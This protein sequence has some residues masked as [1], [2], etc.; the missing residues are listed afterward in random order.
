[1]PSSARFY[2]NNL[3]FYSYIAVFVLIA[4]YLYFNP[5]VGRDYNSYLEIV[6]K[7]VEGE[8]FREPGFSIVVI[9]LDYIGVSNA[10][11]VYFF[12]LLCVALLCRFFLKSPTPIFGL[13]FFILTPNILIGTFNALQTWLSIA[14]FFQVIQLDSYHKVSSGKCFLYAILSASFHVAGLFFIAAIVFNVLI[15]RLGYIPV[16]FTSLLLLPLLIFS[17]EQVITYLGFT[18]YLISIN[19]VSFVSLVLSTL[20]VF[21][22]ISLNYFYP[23]EARGMIFSIVFTYLLLSL[24]L[25]SFSIEQQVYLRFL[26]YILLL[27]YI[28][29]SWFLCRIEL[30]FA[31]VVFVLFSTLLVF[32]FINTVINIPQDMF[33]FEQL[34]LII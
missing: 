33:N 1:M 29:F 26:N 31:G 13:I 7:I 21:S 6:V 20:I 10:G 34:K 2:G 27:F 11:I 25:F 22:I 8:Y 9:A 14:I 18:K 28:V 15:K 17:F 12:R 4:F 32:N 24:A 16:I 3:K 5:V 19:P 23:S 30:K